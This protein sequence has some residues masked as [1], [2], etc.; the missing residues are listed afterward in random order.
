MKY[1]IV[2]KRFLNGFL[3]F[4][5]RTRVKDDI[6]GQTHTGIIKIP[7]LKLMSDLSMRLGQDATPVLGTFKAVG[8]PV[9]VKGNKKAMEIILLDD[10]IDS[11]L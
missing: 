4:E 7:K 9:G 3:T 10:D 11:D 5:G 6:T 2:E 1:L 8:Y